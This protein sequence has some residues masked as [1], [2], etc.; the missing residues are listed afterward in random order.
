MKIETRTRKLRAVPA[1]A[2]VAT[3]AAGF[4]APSMA[5]TAAFPDVPGIAGAPAEALVQ[6]AATMA[7]PRVKAAQTA[8]AA[9]KFNPGPIDGVMGPKTTAA[10]KAFQK[11]RGMAQTGNL[12]V[13]TL[14]ALN[15][16]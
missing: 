12:D 8:L 11:A 1:A 4:A 9:Q 3:I 15:V 7:D 13:G 14:S 10:I 6:V 5:L 2:I 16:R